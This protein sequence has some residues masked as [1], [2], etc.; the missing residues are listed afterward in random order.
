V[1]RTFHRKSCH[2]KAWTPHTYTLTTMS[3]WAN[4]QMTPFLRC[5]QGARSVWY[6]EGVFGLLAWLYIYLLARIFSSVGQNHT[7][8]CCIYLYVRYFKLGNHK[9]YGRIR[10]TIYNFGQP[11]FSPFTLQMPNTHDPSPLT[12]KLK[13]LNGAGTWQMKPSG[14]HFFCYISTAAKHQPPKVT[15]RCI[16]SPS[17]CAVCV[18]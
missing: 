7:C 3:T 16:T 17:S 2:S 18:F 4:H 12:L 14:V 10:C 15:G 8:V 11:S 1:S 5:G 13:L 9:I 6:L